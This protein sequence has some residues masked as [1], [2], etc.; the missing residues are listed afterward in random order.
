MKRFNTHWNFTPKFAEVNSGEIVT[1][2]DH[3]LTVH[4]I[5]AKYAEGTLPSLMKL[6]SGE[7]NP[8]FED[9]DETQVPNYDLVDAQMSMFELEQNKKLR[10]KLFEEQKQAGEKAK[11]EAEKQKII[12]EYTA[13]LKVNEPTA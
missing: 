10:D 4:E 1:V 7:E 8:D 12:D 9:V 3:A 5:L 6:G 11:K 2:P 13:S